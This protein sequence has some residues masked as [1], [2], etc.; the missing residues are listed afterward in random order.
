VSKAIEDTAGAW[1]N[2]QVDAGL[3]AQELDD[4]EVAVIAGIL[5]R[6]NATPRSRE[7]TTI[8]RYERR[9]PKA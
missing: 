1:L 3:L 8:R 2:A 9:R 5:L 4:G 6:A 7:A